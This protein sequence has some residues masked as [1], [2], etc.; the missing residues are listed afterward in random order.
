MRLPAAGSECDIPI[1]AGESGAAGLAGLLSV[2]RTPSYVAFVGLVPESRVLL[3][4]T[5]GATAPVVYETLL[6]ET[7]VSVVDRQ[8]RWLNR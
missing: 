6:N 2:A 3:I 7:A 5:E 4:N 8:V 1:V